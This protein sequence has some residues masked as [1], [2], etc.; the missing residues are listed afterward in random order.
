MRYTRFAL[1]SVA[2]LVAGAVVVAAQEE[3]AGPKLAIPET[4]LAA[5]PPETSIPAPIAW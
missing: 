4:V 3:A 5:E 2:A 1:L